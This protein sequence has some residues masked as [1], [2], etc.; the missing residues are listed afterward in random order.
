MLEHGTDGIVFGFLHENGTVDAKRTGEFAAMAKSYGKQSVFSR[1]IDVTPDWRAALDTLIQSGITRVLTSGQRPTAMEG[2]DVIA[3][4]V[5][6]AAGRIEILPGSGIRANNLRLIL[7]RTGCTQLH[8]SA[9]MIAHDMSAA[10]GNGICF[11]AS[12]IPKEGC[13]KLI[14]QNKVEEIAR[15]LKG[16]ANVQL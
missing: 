1:A 14:D 8:M 16:D 13:Y 9:H 15:M 3:A 10:N 4:M 12:E 11:T 5:R 6:Y 7:E 2:A